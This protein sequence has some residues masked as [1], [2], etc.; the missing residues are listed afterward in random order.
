MSGEQSPVVSNL[1]SGVSEMF[2]PE[3]PP[4]MEAFNGLGRCRPWDA[5][6]GR[7]GG[8]GGL[9]TG[10]D[11]QSKRTRFIDDGGGDHG[12]L[13]QGP[14]RRRLSP[15]QVLK[16]GVPLGWTPQC[17]GAQTFGPRRR[18]DPHLLWWFLGWSQLRYSGQL[19]SANV[20]SATFARVQWQQLM[21]ET[22][23]LGPCRDPHHLWWFLGWSQRRTTAQRIVLLWEAGS[24]FPPLVVS[25]RSNGILVVPLQSRS[26]YP[27]MAPWQD[28]THT[29]LTRNWSEL[30]AHNLFFRS[31]QH[32]WSGSYEPSMSLP[33]VC[34]DGRLGGFVPTASPVGAAGIWSIWW[35]HT[36]LPDLSGFGFANQQ[37]V[38]GV[39]PTQDNSPDGL[40]LR[41]RKLPYN[42]WDWPS[43][44]D[45]WL[46]LKADVTKA[47]LRIKIL[48]AEWKCQITRWED[49][50]WIN[51]VGTYGMASA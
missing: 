16:D 22:R 29:A 24:S 41:R 38:P 33:T 8:E 7:A 18:P 47:H 43:K 51:K 45:E 3:P 49:E 28:Q 40:A 36:I 13:R 42:H 11:P 31:Q 32:S 6:R 48:P 19:W 25:H 12:Q 37:V 21:K 10:V 2:E 9:E 39:E 14:R 1:L 17:Y 20:T 34:L 46:L 35:D 50:W 30:T 27:P 4:V 26:A 15:R 5:A 44:N 23:V